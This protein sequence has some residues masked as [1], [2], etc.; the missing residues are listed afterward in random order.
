[1]FSESDVSASQVCV[2]CRC[3]S[4]IHTNLRKH[5]PFTSTS[6]FQIYKE[7]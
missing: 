6:V 2:R 4:S 5:N 7:I 3:S 1:V